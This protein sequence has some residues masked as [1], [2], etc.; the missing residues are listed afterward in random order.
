MSTV[1]LDPTYSL[2]LLIVCL[3]GTLV[4]PPSQAQTAVADRNFHSAEQRVPPFDQSEAIPSEAVLKVAPRC[5][6]PQSE[7]DALSVPPLVTQEIASE[8]L[9]LQPDGATPGRNQPAAAPSAEPGPTTPLLTRQPILPTADQLRQGEILLNLRYRQFFQGG[10]AQESGVTGQPT[11]GITAGATSGLEL[12]LDAQTVDNAG[13][14]RQ[15]EFD[16]A[17]VNND[18]DGGAPGGP[19]FLNELTFLAKQRLWQ[20]DS[21]SLALSGAAAI[22]LGYAAR[23]FTYTGNGIRGGGTSPQLV[24][25]LEVPLTYRPSDRWQITVSPKVAFFVD[26]NAMYFTNLNGQVPGNFGTTFG[27]AGAVSYRFNSRVVLWGDAFV[28]FTGNNTINRDTGA[29]AKVPVF[30]AGLRYLVNP[31]LSLDLFASNALGNTGPLSIV[32]DRDYPALGVGVTWLPGLTGSNRDYPVAFAATQQPP[33]V[34]ASG[35]APLLGNTLPARVL[36]MNIGGGGQGLLASARYGLMDD[37][38]IGFFTDVISGQ[39]DESEMGISGKI[40]FLHQGDGDPFTLSALATVSRSNNVMINFVD[41]N[42]NALEDKGLKEGGFV[43]GNED[44]GE[45]VVATISIPMH[46]QFAS[47]SALWLTPIVGYVQRSGWE[48]AGLNL[49][50]TVPLIQDFRAIAE[51]G[52][53][54]VGPGNAFMGDTRENVIPWI[55]GLRWE[56]GSFMK[57]MGLK[58]DSYV[59]NRVGWSPFHTMR[60]RADNDITFGVNLTIPVR[61]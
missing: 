49:G 56:P 52:I 20:N 26:S 19:N 48:I 38:E 6:S 42:R 22:S 4:S 34:T 28:P 57:L 53:N 18:P 14:G 9:P 54:L 17:R 3:S 51:V 23:P 11:L 13:P 30:N 25:S 8:P 59:T 35:F 16:V 36:M 5:F 1:R 37:L 2:T 24:P 58:L 33:P 7:P 45:L 61:F 46:Y 60:V 31:R 29:P 50:G 32:G 55:V 43:L 47:G 44:E 39:V 40:R 12:T 41:N 21:G 27:L 10:T 15:G